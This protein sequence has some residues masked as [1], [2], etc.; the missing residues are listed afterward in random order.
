V[1]VCTILGGGCFVIPNTIGKADLSHNM[2]MR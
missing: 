2:K 1:K